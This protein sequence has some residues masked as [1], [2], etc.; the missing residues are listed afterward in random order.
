[1]SL[2]SVFDLPTSKDQLESSNQGFSEYKWLEKAA[3]R[4]VVDTATVQ[5]FN[6]GQ[7][8]F[9]WD[10]SSNTFFMPN[11]C[12]LRMRCKLTKG[13]NTTPLDSDDGIA[14]AMGLLPNLMNEMN[15]TINDQQVSVADRHIAEIE[16]M[17]MRLNKSGSWLKDA[18][19][20]LNFW[21]SSI[22]KRI[23]E[24][25]SDGQLS[26]FYSG[27]DNVQIKAKLDIG[28]DANETIQITAADHVLTLVGG[29]ADARNIFKAGDILVIKLDADVFSTAWYVVQP[30]N[31]LEVQL[32]SFGT[33]L[34][35]NYPV[36]PTAN[37]TMD[38]Y[39]YSNASI[40][41]LSLGDLPNEQPAMAAGNV[42]TIAQGDL[43]NI[44]NG[45]ISLLAL[46][47]NGI[48]HGQPYGDAL[49][50]LTATMGSFNAQ[51]AVAANADNR[52]SAIRYDINDVVDLADLGY[53]QDNQNNGH[54]VQIAPD[55]A[56]SAILT[57]TA[58]GG[59]AIPSVSDNFKIGDIITVEV[60]SGGASAIS[61][62]VIGIDPSANGASLRVVG[63][64]VLAGA[65]GS[66]ND[67][68]DYLRKRI[69]HGGPSKTEASINKARQ[70]TEFE[71]NWAPRCLSFFKLPHAM[72]GG[73]KYQLN[74]TAKNLYREAA[75]ESLVNKVAG[76]DYNFQVLNFYLYIPTF[77]G[78]PH[79]D[80][81][82]FYL[83]LNEIRCQKVDITTQETSY[84]M[85]VRPST[86]ALATCIQ[87]S[88]VDNNTNFSA[89][90][91]VSEND[92]QLKLNKFHVRF[93]NSQKPIPNFDL[94]YSGA[95]RDASGN[96]VNGRDYWNQ[97]YLRNLLA[98][99]AYFD[100]SCESIQEY[101]ERGNYIF[102]NWSRSAD[103]RE[104][105]VFIQAGFS[106]SPTSVANSSPK[107]L[108][109]NF[110]K[111]YAIC[112]LDNGRFQEIL[113]QEA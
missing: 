2:K 85:D 41:N 26:E 98:T 67:G 109:F 14:P 89:S 78:R 112:K 9:R 42:L 110:Y 91:F 95:G 100:S 68:R 44:K 34:A 15:M 104:T 3:L 19:Q 97:V 50:P 92:Y 46:E 43:S 29:S 37:Y 49:S 22:H 51:T 23:Q 93:G 39:R 59:D 28:L 87:S 40:V 113:L 58:T 77:Q 105:R 36:A 6:R 81:Y 108:L 61:A 33:V 107:L 4:N 17:Y 72:C 103:E 73:A 75:I 27:S 10:M 62:L 11:K 20:S 96:I 45:D 13:D 12:F 60:L 16:A 55:G 53:I 83:D 88:S 69:R 54:A 86:N 24:V 74:M 35:G 7:I 70:L 1:M 84:T 64:Q 94:D 90:K 25:S 30:L 31:A 101:Y 63:E 18:G 21:E 76:T 57:I 8:S 80:R 38:R 47:A 32:A 82:Q 106:E 48:Y 79:I 66:V 65:R 5:N 56:G 111:K 99:G 102:Q 71:I 52:W